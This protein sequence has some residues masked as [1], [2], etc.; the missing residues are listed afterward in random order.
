VSLVVQCTHTLR[1]TSPPYT[2]ATGEE[3]AALVE[4]VGRQ[5]IDREAEFVVEFANMCPN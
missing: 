4:V 3:K 2:L 1:K 5:Q